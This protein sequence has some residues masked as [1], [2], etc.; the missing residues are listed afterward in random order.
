VNDDRRPVV[1]ADAMNHL[2]LA[3]ALT[4][5]WTV[6]AGERGGHPDAGAPRKPVKKKVPDKDRDSRGEEE[7]RPATDRE[8]RP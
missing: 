3:A 4:I 7:A 5:A 8:A 1:E 6:A 2:L